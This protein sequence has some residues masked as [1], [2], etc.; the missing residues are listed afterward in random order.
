MLTAKAQSSDKVL[1]LTAGGDDFVVVVTPDTAEPVAN[2]IIERFE[3]E[4]PNLYDREDIERGFVEVED[5]QGNPQKFPPVSISIGIATTATRRFSHYGEAIT[6]AA[7]MKQ[8]A[9]RQAGSAF[10]VDRRHA[11]GQ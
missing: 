7:E 2:R 6:V 3:R 5:R 11:V 9:K 10:A 8:F 1:G 4:I